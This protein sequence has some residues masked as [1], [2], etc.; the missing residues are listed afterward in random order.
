MD[1]SSDSC[2]VILLVNCEK[3]KHIRFSTEYFYSFLELSHRPGYVMA[4]SSYPKIHWEVV[5]SLQSHALRLLCIPTQDLQELVQ[6]GQMSRYKAC[7]A[8]KT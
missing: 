7:M 1:I 2:V 8:N 4:I 6:R 3:A 5:R